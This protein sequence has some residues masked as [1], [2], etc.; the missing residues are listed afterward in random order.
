MPS[1]LLLNYIKEHPDEVAAQLE[2]MPINQVKS[3]I[4]QLPT[5]ECARLIPHL[6][7]KYMVEISDS[8]DDDILE[9]LCKKQ[10]PYVVLRIYNTLSDAEQASFLPKL[11]RRFRW[12]LKYLKSQ[13]MQSISTLMS[14][15]FLS[16]PHTTKVNEALISIKNIRQKIFA[17]YVHDDKNKVIGELDAK[18]L[19]MANRNNIINNHIKPIRDAQSPSAY[20]GDV[21]SLTVWR[22]RTILPIIDH[23]RHLLGIISINALLEEMIRKE[24]EERI[25]ARDSIEQL[26]NS[27]YSVLNS[28][29]TSYRK[30]N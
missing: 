13:S 1:L 10:P 21:I 14:Y 30:G 12:Y 2:G 3:L 6:S 11:P 26:T 18:D 27:I 25:S 5:A 22:K 29:A 16:L 23:D 9:I 17:L 4:E 28:I 19:Y 8:I 7:M 15:D 20:I 24:N